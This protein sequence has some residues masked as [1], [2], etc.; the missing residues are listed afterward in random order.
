METSLNDCKSR[1][2]KSPECDSLQMLQ[3]AMRGHALVKSVGRFVHLHVDSV[4]ASAA[5]AMH[6]GRV[7]ISVITT[8]GPYY[9][10]S[11]VVQV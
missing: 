1:V 7:K 3:I 10:Y 8:C 9:T 6:Q 2:R 4:E 11:A 5:Q